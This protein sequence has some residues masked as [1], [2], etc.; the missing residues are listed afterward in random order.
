MARTACRPRTAPA[1]ETAK[2]NRCR[3]PSGPHPFL[4]RGPLSSPCSQ[5]QR[6]RMVQ[7]H[8]AGTHAVSPHAASKPCTTLRMSCR[9]RRAASCRSWRGVGHQAPKVHHN[10]TTFSASEASEVAVEVPVAAA[11]ATVFTRP[12]PG[13]GAVRLD[14]EHRNTGTVE[15]WNSGKRMKKEKRDDFQ[16]SLCQAQGSARSASAKARGEGQGGQREGQ[17]SKR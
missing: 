8:A 2:K 11:A 6:C 14:L 4:P 5:G 3:P 13:P 17:G 15:Q 9:S 16:A 7:A 10:T 1:W 12:S